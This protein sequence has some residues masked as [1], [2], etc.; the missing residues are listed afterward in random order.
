[1][2]K[3]L[4]RTAAFGEQGVELKYPASSWSGVRG[5]DG[6]VLF[7]VRAEEVIV[8]GD[9]SRCLLWTPDWKQARSPASAERLEHCM[10]ALQ[11][12]QAEGMLAFADGS[13]IDPTSVLS[14]RVERHRREYWAKWGSVACPMAPRREH[15]RPFFVG[16]YA[17]AASG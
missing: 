15:L 12:G 13:Q 16:D 14:L 17:L 10:L 4:S 6:M 11:H 1:M 8:D 2:L 7:A 3:T 9:G 5:D